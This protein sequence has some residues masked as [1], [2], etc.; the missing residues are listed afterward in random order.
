MRWARASASRSAGRVVAYRVTSVMVCSWK[1]TAGWRG[2][3]SVAGSSPNPCSPMRRFVSQAVEFLAPHCRCQRA[4]QHAERLAEPLP[5]AYRVEFW[6]LAWTCGWI[7]WSSRLLPPGSGRST[8]GRDA[9]VRAC[10]TALTP[11]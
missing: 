5:A 1:S 4:E 7:A 11:A 6:L 2:S 10:V 3:A 9:G 8:T